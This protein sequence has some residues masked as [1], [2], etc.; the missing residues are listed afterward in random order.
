MTCTQKTII[1]SFFKVCQRGVITLALLFSFSAQCAND[2]V[3]SLQRNLLT[4]QNRVQDLEDQLAESEGQI[5]SLNH[6]IEVLRA[7]NLK[8]KNSATAAAQNQDALDKG[9]AQKSEVNNSAVA[10]NQNLSS[11]VG[12]SSGTISKSKLS[13]QNALAQSS[14]TQD[15]KTQTQGDGLPEADE[16]ANRQY[17]NA[18]KLLTQNKLDEAAKAFNVYVSKYPNNSLTPNAWY[19][20]GQVQYKQKKYAEARVSFLNTAKFKNSSKRADA[21]YKLGITSSALGDNEKAKRFYE[22]LIK[23]YPASSSAVLAKKELAKLN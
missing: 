14:I 7:E 4:L 1:H 17:Q 11:S 22:V 21:L 18:Y 15:K 6:E 16:N 12:D 8:L 3:V 10:A 2:Q 20:L 23:T 13:N 5:E 9:E 19:W